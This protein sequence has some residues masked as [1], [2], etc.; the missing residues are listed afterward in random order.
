MKMKKVLF[1]LP[2]LV[3]LFFVGC[4][5]DDDIT[6]QTETIESVSFKEKN[7]SI[8]TGETLNLEYSYS[9]NIQ[10]VQ[11]NWS[12]SNTEIVSVT[13][14]GTVQGLKAGEAAITIEISYNGINVTDKCNV[15]VSD[16]KITDISLSCESL[17]LIEKQSNK[18]DA[19]VSPTNATDK[20]LVWISSDESIATVNNGI[21]T[22]ISQGECTI[23]VSTKDKSI[24]KSCEINVKGIN[25]YLT[26]EQSHGEPY[27]DKHDSKYKCTFKS[28]ITN[29]SL[30][31]KVELTSFEA[32]VNGI[33][34]Q[35]VERQFVILNGKYVEQIFMQNPTLEKGESLEG[36]SGQLM[37]LKTDNPTTYKIKWNFVFNDSQYSIEK[38]L[39][40]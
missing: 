6:K 12:S 10:G 39:P 33:L 30:N 37:D 31:G 14:S 36:E 13:P 2:I 23:S 11:I 27:W 20:E 35:E 28:T 5:S 26:M 38:E 1:I 40:F 7:I 34:V 19:T 18:I 16:I 8:N 24:T 4:S 22:G 9:P 15:V 17:E 29:S 25:E 21:I 3:V 32:Y